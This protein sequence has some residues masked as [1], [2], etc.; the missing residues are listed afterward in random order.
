[1]R[2]IVRK[3]DPADMNF[4][5]NSFLR[6]QRSNKRFENVIN[7]IYFPEQTRVMHSMLRG[8]KVL[9]ICNSEHPDHLF[10]Y[11]VGSPDKTTHFIYVKHPYRKMGLGRKLMEHLHPSLY[12][13]TL[14]ASYSCPGWPELS[15]KFRH[16]FNP[17]D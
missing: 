5:L 17:Y 7:E 2:A 6:S 11:V 13:K 10:G 9:V 15:S 16:L 3:A 12:K 14:Q 4:I 8:S 1:M